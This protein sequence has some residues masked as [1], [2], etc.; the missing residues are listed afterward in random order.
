[1]P[2][3][4]GTANDADY[5]TVYWDAPAANGLVITSYS[6]QFRRHDSLY[7]EDDT[8]CI[9]NDADLLSLTECTIPLQKLLG[10]PYLLN[11][12]EDVN[13]K[14]SATNAYGT[15]DLSAVGTGAV[16]QIIPDAP[17]NVANDFSTST[18]TQIR[19]TWE[20]GPSD[21]GSGVIDYEVYFDQAINDWINVASNL[22]DIYSYTTTM[23]LTQGTS[24][25]FKVRSRNTV[26]FS[27]FSDVLIVLAA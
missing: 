21:G 13:V 5:V 4:L 9:G 22:V 10:D 27:D 24:Y 15:S 19:I 11:V 25:G 16:I 7:Y 3:V 2:S 8:E 23:A 20:E 14:I 26:G 18:A 17:I 6:V 12:G 1:V